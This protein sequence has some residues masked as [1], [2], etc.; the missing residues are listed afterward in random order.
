MIIMMIIIMVI[1]YMYVKL[2]I[3]IIITML[4]SLRDHPLTANLRTQTLDFRG[5]DSSIVNLHFKGWSS[6][7]HRAPAFA[8]PPLKCCFDQG[9]P[10][11]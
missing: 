9:E 2:M 8:A 7:T 3:L 6:Q 10:P 1:I 11:V 5:F 4:P